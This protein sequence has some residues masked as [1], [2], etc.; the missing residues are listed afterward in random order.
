MDVPNTQRLAFRLMNPD[1]ATDAKL[2]WQLDQDPEVMR[3]IN[4]GTM[5]SM[6]DIH[7]IFIPRM[8]KYTNSDKGWG[9]W[10]V[11]TLDSNEFIGW[12]LVRPMDFFNDEPKFNDLE[13]GWR[14]FQKSWGNGYASEAAEAVKLA[15]IDNISEQNP[16]EYLSALALKEN[17]GSV[18]VMKKIGMEFIKDFFHKDPLGDMDA[19]LYRLKTT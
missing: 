18:A 9:L 16:V 1:S 2:L 11:S 13:L 12:V 5:T 15:L 10:H 19:V 3:F 8:A 7:A 6:E 17:Y 14:F 4:G